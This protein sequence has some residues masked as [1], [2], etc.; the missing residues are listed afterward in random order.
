MDIAF[1]DCLSVGSFCYALIL[2]DQ[3]TCYNWT[4][5][6]KTLLLDSILATKRLFCSAA[7]SLACCFYCDCNAKCFG[8]VISEYLI[9]NCSK[10]VAAPAKQQLSNGPLED[11]GAHGEGVFD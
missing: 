11:Y 9:D 3:G 5:G 6:L 4:F 8:T 1:G 2:V 10:V 7:G